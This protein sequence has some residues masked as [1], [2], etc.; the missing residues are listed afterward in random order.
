[1]S[2]KK[3]DLYRTAIYLRLSSGDEDRGT[4]KT[5]S[6]SITNQRLLITEYI[7]K[8]PEFKLVDTF[9]DDGFT[10]SNFNRPGYQQLMKAM[11][12]GKIDCII[13]KDLSRIAREH[14]G[15]DEL[16][17]KTFDK[18]GVRFIAITDGFDSLTADHGEKHIMVPIKNLI[19]DNYCQ[20][21]STK[22]RFITD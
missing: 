21:I 17:L 19:N 7:S 5:D 20:D 1:M 22:V 8:R 18:Y 16:I 9:I 2:I 11:E 12:D 3:L 13:V 4:D 15:G 10:G 6:N 14:I